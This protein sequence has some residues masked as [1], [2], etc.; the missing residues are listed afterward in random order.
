MQNSK[1]EKQVESLTLQNSNLEKQNTMLIIENSKLQARIVELENQLK[2]LS[3]EKKKLESS[4]I[5]LTTKMD[6]MKRNFR[7][8][9][10]LDDADHLSNA[11]ANCSH[12]DCPLKQQFE[13]F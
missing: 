3:D 10:S 11:I 13:I 7:T 5:E 8:V 9:T 6:V 2:L 12:S 4:I 1:L